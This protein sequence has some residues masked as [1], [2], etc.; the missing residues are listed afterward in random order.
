LEELCELHNLTLSNAP[1][2]L[3][4]VPDVDALAGIFIP[5]EATVTSYTAGVKMLLGKLIERI[6][7]GNEEWKQLLVRA[8]ELKGAGKSWSD[9]VPEINREFRGGFTTESFNN[10]LKNNRRKAKQLGF[11]Y[12]TKPKANP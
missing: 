1:G 5:D 2:L 10:F 8:Y 7:L 11:N 4:H 9:V 3:G 6:R 12:M